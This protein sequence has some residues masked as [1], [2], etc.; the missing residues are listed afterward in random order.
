M[1]VETYLI[2]NG[3]CEEA[4]NFYKEKLGAE[5]NC[6]MRFSENP[7]PA[8]KAMITPGTENKVMHSLF[9]IRDTTLMAADSYYAG[10]VKFEGF[11]LT[12]NVA[13]AAEAEKVFAALGEGGKAEQPLIET[14]FAHRFGMV[15]DKFGISW[16]IL[17]EKK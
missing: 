10:G 4:L 11:S 6:M 15:T 12:L 3:R 8:S 13:D 2:F 16:M 1:F 17:A 14:F 5:V 7:D 9:R